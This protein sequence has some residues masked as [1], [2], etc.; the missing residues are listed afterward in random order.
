MPPPP[1]STIM[2]RRKRTRSTN[3]AENSLDQ[4]A[5][6]ASVNVTSLPANTVTVSASPKRHRNNPPPV[7]PRSILPRPNYSL[8]NRSVT[9]GPRH[10]S[11][12]F[13]SLHTP[14]SGSSIGQRY[15]LRPRHPQ[16]QV[17]LPHVSTSNTTLATRRIRRPL[18]SV[19]PATTSTFIPTPALSPPSLPPALPPL[20]PPLLPPVLPTI[21]SSLTLPTPPIIQ[22]RQYRLVYISEDDDDDEP[23]STTQA[24][25]VNTAF[26]LMTEDGLIRPPVAR[27]RASRS[28]SGAGLNT[29]YTSPSLLSPRSLLLFVLL[30][31]EQRPLFRW[32]CRRVR[33]VHRRPHHRTPWQASIA[34]ISSTAWPTFG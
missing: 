4:P 33:P 10:A 25:V 13:P 29:R 15:H 9:P 5:S 17:R 31:Y 12:R 14:A 18:P 1:L 2:T 32:R 21:V 8:R 30:V 26:N 16:S 22:P 3:L 24:T 20:P 27:R 6:T 11:T 34:M 28:T 23:R 7:P 19:S